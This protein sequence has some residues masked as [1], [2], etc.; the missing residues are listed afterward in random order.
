LI[1][2]T[3]FF[4][5]PTFSFPPLRR[6]Q[7]FSGAGLLEV[8]SFRFRR[9]ITLCFRH[10]LASA[11]FLIDVAVLRTTDSSFSGGPCRVRQ[12]EFGKEE[13]AAL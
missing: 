1:G 12:P 11:D 5:S 3:W 8:F 4:P 9:G 10:P 2:G 7:F 13:E 6:W